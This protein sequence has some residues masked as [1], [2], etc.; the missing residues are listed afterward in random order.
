LRRD[1]KVDILGIDVTHLVLEALGHTDD[2]VVD[3]G[4][5]SSEGGD[6]LAR[7]VVELNLDGIGLGLHRLSIFG[8]LITIPGQTHRR[9]ADSQVTERLGQFSLIL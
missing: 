9:E 6:A 8:R 2:Q 1:S 7:S 3:E 4:A 5:D